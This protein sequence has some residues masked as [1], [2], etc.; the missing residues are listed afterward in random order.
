MSVR[1]RTWKNAKGETQESWIVDYVDQKGKRHIKTFKKKKA[2]DAYHATVRVEVR[3]GVHT[4]DSASLTVEEAGK[5]WIKTAEANALERTTVVDYRRMLELHIAPRIGRVRLSQLSAPMV[6]DFEDQL[7]EAGTS[8]AMVRK[9][10]TA[11]SMLLA[12]SQ[13]RGLVNRNVAR[14]LRR[15][16]ERKADRRQKG[17]LKIGVDIPAPDEI[18]AIIGKRPR[19]GHA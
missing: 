18:R 5:F 10:R 9:I 12:D 19:C 15:G 17:K 11:L 13:E 2:A 3:Q 6:R 16:R 7:R 14:E 4:P 8:P 1:K